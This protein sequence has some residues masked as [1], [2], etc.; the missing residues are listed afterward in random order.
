MAADRRFVHL[1]E[2]RLLSNS[3]KMRDQ[4]IDERCS[5]IQELERLSGN[6]SAYKTREEL[7]GLQKDDLIKAMEMRKVAL[8][9]RLQFLKE[10]DFYKSL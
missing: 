1:E 7:K 5:F 6:L 4:F 3:T 2:L 10:L 8:Q 9:L